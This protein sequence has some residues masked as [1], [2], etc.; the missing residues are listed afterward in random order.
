MCV[1]ALSQNH[2]STVMKWD[3]E[4]IVWIA[5]VWLNVV[6]N[7]R[8]VIIVQIVASKKVTASQ[9]FL[10]KTE[11][12]GFGLA[13]RDHIP[14]GTF[15]IEYIGEVLNTKQF[16]KRDDDYYFM[17]LPDGHVIDASNKGNLSRFINHSCDPNSESQKWSVN[18]ESRIGIFSTKDIAKDEEITYNY[19]LNLDG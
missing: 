19:H 14:A 11:K 10:I 15:I 9:A 17:A 5:R 6:Q 3:A 1:V 2:K 12:K 18:G 8:S 13:A 16:E 4:M 7:V